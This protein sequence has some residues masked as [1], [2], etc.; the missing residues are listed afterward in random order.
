M[1]RTDKTNDEKI[2]PIIL[3]N[4][5]SSEISEIL[6]EHNQERLEMYDKAIGRHFECEESVYEVTNMAIEKI[7]EGTSPKD[8]VEAIE[9]C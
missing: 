6:H 8:I 1:H 3:E 9:N 5:S 2:L 7:A 4:K